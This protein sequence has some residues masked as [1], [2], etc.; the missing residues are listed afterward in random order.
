MLAGRCLVRVTSA[1]GEV[2][3][4]NLHLSDASYV[5]CQALSDA[6]HVMSSPLS[7]ARG[8]PLCPYRLQCPLSDARHVLG[9]K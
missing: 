2:H 6:H 7:D 4:A 8:A 1:H 9:S 3:A 5:S